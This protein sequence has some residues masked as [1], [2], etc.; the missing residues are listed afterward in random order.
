MGT[1]R[2]FRGYAIEAVNTAVGKPAGE[3]WPISNNGQC[4]GKKVHGCVNL[5]SHCNNRDKYYVKFKWISPKNGS[6]CITFR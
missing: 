3:L 1:Q 6:G 2:P 4:A 5:I